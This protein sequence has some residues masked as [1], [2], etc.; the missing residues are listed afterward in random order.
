MKSFIALLAILSLGLAAHPTLAFEGGD[1]LLRVGFITVNPSDEDSDTLTLNGAKLPGTEVDK[2]EKDTQVGF[3]A[4]YLFTSY[5]GLELLAATPFTHD[6]KVKGLGALGIREVGDTKELPPT[7]SAVL[8][9]MGFFK[10]ASKFQPYVGLGLNYTMFWDEDASSELSKGL[11]QVTGVDENYNMDLDDSWGIAAQ[12]G[13]DYLF[14]EHLLV[15]VA[16]RWINIETDATF[17]GRETGTRVKADDVE[18]NPWV[19]SISVGY[20]F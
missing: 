9:P 12:A 16:L 19:Y 11:G 1:I 20:R 14:T 10:P 7:L 2:V 4:A 18:I 17:K 8:Y 6:V 13:I 15:N 5:F 3:T